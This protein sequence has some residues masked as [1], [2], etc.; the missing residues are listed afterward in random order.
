MLFRT[1][2][3]ILR[4]TAT[5]FQ[6][7]VVREGHIYNYSKK[8]TVIFRDAKEST[9]T[10]GVHVYA[11]NREKEIQNRYLLHTPLRF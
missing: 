5:I 6:M 8:A 3:T 7:T 1:E 9:E 10:A 4:S 2:S 11:Q